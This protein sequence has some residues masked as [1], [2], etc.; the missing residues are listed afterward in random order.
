MNLAK[1][2]WIFGSTIM[3]ILGIIHLILTFLT[4]KFSPKDALLENAMRKTSPILTNDLTMWNGWQGFNASHSLGIIIFGL[5][6]IYLVFRYFKV[7]QFD[8]VYFFFNII[9][10]GAYIFLAYKYWF[11]IPLFGLL[12]TFLCF[13]LSYFLIIW[14]R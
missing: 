12:L 14:N 11:N 5:I 13:G 10:I 7:L 2:I 8:N 9:V 3:V 6:N 1:F 4:D